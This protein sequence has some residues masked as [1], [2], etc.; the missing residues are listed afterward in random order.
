MKDLEDSKISIKVE[1]GNGEKVEIT[2][3]AD[4]KDR[5]Q[6]LEDLEKGNE[7]AK[8]DSLAKKK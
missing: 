6:T 1:N 7:P 5:E 3:N 8:K 2:T 4:K